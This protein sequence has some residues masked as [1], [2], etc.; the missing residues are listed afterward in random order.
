MHQKWILS[1]AMLLVAGD[2]VG[3]ANSNPRDTG[4]TSNAKNHSEGCEFYS[5]RGCF[6]EPRE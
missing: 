4:C 5:V 2:R 1:S 3:G 6:V